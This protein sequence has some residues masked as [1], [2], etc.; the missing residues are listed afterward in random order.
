MLYNKIRP[1]LKKVARPDFS[2][3]CS[4]D[5]YPLEVDSE[6]ISRDFLYYI[7]LSK[8]LLTMR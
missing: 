7:L 6:K 5:M 4:A 3:L 2:G 1:Y 8:T